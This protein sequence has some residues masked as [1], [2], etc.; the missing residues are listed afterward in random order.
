M[1]T[2]ATSS[3]CVCGTAASPFRGTNQPTCR[4]GFALSDD[5][6]TTHIKA[7]YEHRKGIDRHQR[8]IRTHLKSAL[9][10]ADDEDDDI[11]DDPALLEDD[12]DEKSF[13]AELKQ[14]V[15]QATALTTT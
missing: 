9:D 2:F 6:R 14:L 5:E 8:C 12:D 11:E 13:L 10:L 7:I 1:G 3:S 4:G 15:E